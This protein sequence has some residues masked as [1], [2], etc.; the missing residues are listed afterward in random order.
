M[1]KRMRELQAQI[2]E[3]TS[4]AKGY[5]EGENKDMEK[6]AAILDEV[7]VLQKEFETLGRIEQAAKAGVPAEPETQKPGQVDA[8]KALATAARSG[9]KANM[10]EATPA[11]GGYTV[12]EDIRTAI[13]RYKEERF[14]LRTLI[15]YEH[16]STNKGRRTY[17]TRAQHTGLVKVGEGGKIPQTSAPQFEVMTYEI[18]KYAGYLPVTNELLDDS[19]AAIAN[20]VVEWLGEEELATE[21]AQILAKIAEK[22]ATPFASIDDIKKAVNVTLAAFAGSVRIVTNSDGLQYLDTLKDANKRYLLAPDPTDHMNMYLAVGARRIPVTVVPNAVLPTAESGAIPFIV[23]DLREYMKMFDRKQLTITMS[24]TAAVT[25]FNA[26]E[27]DMTIWRAIMRADWEV[28]DAMSIV[29]GE[30]TPA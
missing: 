9:F 7:D 2:A 8:V 6:A 30:L 13:N 22:E 5:S 20:L 15:D 16:V 23:G 19:D 1:N 28:K 25:G 3:K 18:E 14:S 29:R 26:F 10:N 21:N 24:N 11:D 17:K 4:Q 27:Q 12:P